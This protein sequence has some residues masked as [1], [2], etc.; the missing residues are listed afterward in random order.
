MTKYFDEDYMPVFSL[1]DGKN[2]QQ[3]KPSLERENERESMYRKLSWSLIK[4]ETLDG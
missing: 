2:D 3:L 4:T 1:L